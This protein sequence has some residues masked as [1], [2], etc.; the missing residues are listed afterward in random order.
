MGKRTLYRKYS[1]TSTKL[2]QQAHDLAKNYLKRPH[3]SFSP[4]N[5]AISH[6]SETVYITHDNYTITSK[7]PT[8]LRQQPHNE[9][10]INTICKNA[11]WSKE[12]YKSVDWEAFGVAFSKL[13][14]H[15]Q[16]S[17]SKITHGIINTNAQ[18]QKF[19]GKSGICPSCCEHLETLP[20]MLTCLEVK[21]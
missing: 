2:N 20:H 13:P 3:P 17:T 11:K 12:T 18:N 9:P 5:V 6:P 4:S 15:K 16:I 1:N 7:L 10:L 14:R 8:L 21:H 19:Y